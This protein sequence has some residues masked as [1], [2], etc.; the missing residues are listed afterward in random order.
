MSYIREIKSLEEAWKIANG[1]DHWVTKEEEEIL[2]TVDELLVMK[3]LKSLKREDEPWE[4]YVSMLADT[5]IV[6]DGYPEGE[7]DCIRDEFIFWYTD[8][9]K[10]DCWKELIKKIP[11]KYMKDYEYPL[12][13]ARIVAHHPRKKYDG[14]SV[15]KHIIYRLY[16]TILTAEE[17]IELDLQKCCHALCNEC[18]VTGLI[19]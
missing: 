7:I 16:D 3:F 11:P 1:A 8:F 10:T 4:S 14:N 17:A 12:Q 15:L 13:Q 2:T 6:S 18:S 19:K 9:Y 5:L